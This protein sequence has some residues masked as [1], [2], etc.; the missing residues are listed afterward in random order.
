MVE[1]LCDSGAVKFKAGT[2]ASTTITN[3]PST[4]TL[5]INQAEGEFIAATRVNWITHFSSMSADFK[6]VVEGAVSSKAA[7]KVINYDMGGFNSL[8]EA[9]TMI[10][11]L[12]NEYNQGVK[13]LRDSDFARALG[14]V[15]I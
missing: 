10:N 5:F 15:K 8:G 9:T 4:M 1:T 6:Q 2:N 14:G 7:T 11:I 13:I 12:L 3:E